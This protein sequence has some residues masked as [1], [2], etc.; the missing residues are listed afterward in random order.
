MSTPIV[1]RVNEEDGSNT[2]YH[3]K[4]ANIKLL[5]MINGKTYKFIMTTYEDN[6]IKDYSVYG[7][8]IITTMDEKYIHMVPEIVEE[9]VGTVTNMDIIN[10]LN[11]FR[12][13]QH[14]NEWNSIAD[15][16]KVIRNNNC[17]FHDFANKQVTTDRNYIFN[18]PDNNYSVFFAH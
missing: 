2:Y 8:S 1:F 3:I 12:H 17:L 11:P 14:T 10:F 13:G 7:K 5:N 18:Y 15:Q 6:E 9:N 4:N 16:I